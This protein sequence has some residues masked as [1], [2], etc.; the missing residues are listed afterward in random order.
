MRRKY[1]LGGSVVAAAAV[2]GIL[3]F[4][5]VPGL[6]SA[7]PEPPAAETLIATWLLH[8]SVPDEAKKSVNPL[9]DDLPTS[10]RAK[11]FTA[12]SAKPATP[13]M[14][15]AK[16]P[17]GANEYPR[18]PRCARLRCRRLPDGELFY[19]IRNGIRNT[20]MPAWD[21]PDRQIWQLVSYI[22]HLP[23]VAAM[24]PEAAAALSPPHDHNAAGS[25]T[26]CRIG[27]LQGMP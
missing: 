5:V 12:R 9:K 23:E 3:Y 20:G 15:A 22:R 7:R 27:R 14:A 21:L 16:P 25:R 2:L 13:M 19:H 6:S 10:R 24:T 8:Q 17:I 26:L 18:R 11:I 4:K 1:F